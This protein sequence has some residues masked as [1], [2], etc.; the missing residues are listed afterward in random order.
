MSKLKPLFDK[1]LVEPVKA[2]EKTTGG[3]F[4]PGADKEKPTKG[5]VT[6]VGS[7]ARKEDGSF[8]GMS[9]AVGQTV[10]YNKFGGTEVKIDGSDYLV[11]SES[12]ILGILE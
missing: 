7:G 5:V 11:L 1:V 2:E 6:A 8:A 10:L 9:V 12:N 4:L 3:I